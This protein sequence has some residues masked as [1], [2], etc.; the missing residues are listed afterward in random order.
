MPR[1]STVLL[2]LFAASTTALFKKKSSNEESALAIADEDMPSGLIGVLGELV[3]EG[4]NTAKYRFYFYMAT[5]AK[6]EKQQTIAF[7]STLCNLLYSVSILL[8]FL[9]VGGISRTSMLVFTLVTVLVGP[10]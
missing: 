3:F 2:L 6:L 7:I 8:G 1:F 10:P 9:G 4:L 5:G